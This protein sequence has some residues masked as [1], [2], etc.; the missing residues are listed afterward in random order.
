MEKLPHTYHVNVCGN[1]DDALDTYS[2]DLPKLIVAPPTQ[3]GGPGDKWSPEE[4]LMAAQASCLVLSFRA[5]AMASKL[6]WLTID[7]SSQGT[8]D[9][10]DGKV[11][12]TH[13]VSTVKL[14]LP[15]GESVEKAERL[16]QKA[17]QSCL[18]SNSLNCDTQLQCEI[19][20]Q[21]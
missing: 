2:N 16:L 19:M 11:C 1:P 12:F 17:D 13:M 21:P 10:K 6:S 18:V 15:A 7:C 5:I 9:K 3:F 20:V 4:L 8:L 14:T